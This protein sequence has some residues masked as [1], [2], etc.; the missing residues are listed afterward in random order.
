MFCSMSFTGFSC[1]G[2]NF[3]K[4]RNKRD[5]HAH[6]IHSTDIPGQ[7]RNPPKAWAKP[8]SHKVF[9]TST[10]KSMDG[11]FW[12]RTATVRDHGL[13]TRF[14]ICCSC[15]LKATSVTKA[16]MSSDCFWGIYLKGRIQNNKLQFHCL[17][18]WEW[19]GEWE[20]TPQSVCQLNSLRSHCQNAPLL[21]CRVTCSFSSRVCSW[22]VTKYIQGNRVL[23][24][25]V[26]FENQ[27]CL[28]RYIPSGKTDA[29]LRNLNSL[30]EC[31]CQVTC[32]LLMSALAWLHSLPGCYTALLRSFR[33]SDKY[34]YDP[35]LT[36][37]LGMAHQTLNWINRSLHRAGWSRDMH[38][39]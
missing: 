35:C 20:K 19:R 16:C 11:R 2:Y 39:T 34:C 10:S 38:M 9:S 24:L 8:F 31:I 3:S 15:I 26:P 6:H 1:L 12:S 27:L 21:Y 37:S 36:D 30:T 18:K 7:L 23:L 14:W 25:L 22:E 33:A 13:R 17:H 5:N 32:Y 28:I 29:S 4:L